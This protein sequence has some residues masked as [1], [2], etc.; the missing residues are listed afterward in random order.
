MKLRRLVKTGT[1]LVIGCANIISLMTVDLVCF[2]GIGAC[3]DG[4]LRWLLLMA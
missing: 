4:S 3:L 2:C 1:A